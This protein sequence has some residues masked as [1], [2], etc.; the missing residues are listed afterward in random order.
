MI[1]GKSPAAGG[2]NTDGEESYNGRVVAWVREK[3]RGASW[4]D[5]IIDPAIQTNYDESK[6]E[7]L[8]KVALDCVEEDKDIRP[9]M[10]QVVEMLQSFSQ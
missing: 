1:T 8:A 4:L 9:T 3:R 10:S 7:L 2:Q 5:H 6:M